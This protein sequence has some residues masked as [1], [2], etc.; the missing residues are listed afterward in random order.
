M[1]TWD[2]PSAGPVM[3]W[4]PRC[5]GRWVSRILGGP[6]LWI[7]RRSSHPG[8]PGRE[9]RPRGSPDRRGARSV[10]IP[11]SILTAEAIRSGR[12][13]SWAFARTVDRGEPKEPPGDRGRFPAPS[14]PLLPVP[15]A[16][17]D[18]EPERVGVLLLPEVPGRPGISPVPRPAGI[19]MPGVL[20]DLRRN[21]GSSSS[22]GGRPPEWTVNA[23]LSFRPLARESGRH[24][25]RPLPGSPPGPFGLPPRPRRWRTGG[26]P[27]AHGSVGPWGR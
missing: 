14:R 22:E 24:T 11:P 17:S 1:S 15:M 4:G 26:E 18:Q 10:G 23:R 27:G 2:L 19:G 13:R 9:C 8:R 7:S 25:D 21:R 20:P 12:W 16:E 3:R 5:T 6:S